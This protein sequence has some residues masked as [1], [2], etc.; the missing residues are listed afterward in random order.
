MADKRKRYARAIQKLTGRSFCG[1]LNLMH[2]W[3][4]EGK[5]IHEEDREAIGRQG[6][7]DDGIDGSPTGRSTTKGRRR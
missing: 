4:T 7:Q 3:K 1:A 2:S 6:A 5:N